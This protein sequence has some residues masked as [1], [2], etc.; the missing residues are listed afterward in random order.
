M[1]T[2]TR[3]ILR[4]EWSQETEG[5]WEDEEWI[6]MLIYLHECIWIE[7]IGMSMRDIDGIDGRDSL[8]IEFYFCIAFHEI[9]HSVVREPTID[10][11]P[12]IV[13]ARIRDIDE[14]L[15]VPERSDDHSGVN[16][17][18]SRIFGRESCS[19]IVVVIVILASFF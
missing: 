12:Y 9:A 7:V 18:P 19:I 10:E 2:D 17:I 3:E 15:G 6:R 1:N 5:R 4:K 8:R 13:S 11:D 16:R 14:E